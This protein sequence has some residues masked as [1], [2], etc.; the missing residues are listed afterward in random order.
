M[1][2]TS[3]YIQWEVMGDQWEVMGDQWEVQ[4]IVEIFAQNNHIAAIFLDLIGIDLQNS[5]LHL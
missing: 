2:R 3:F 4:F 1:R 5:S